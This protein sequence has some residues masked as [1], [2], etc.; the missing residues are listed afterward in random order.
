ME[1]TAGPLTLRQLFKNKISRSINTRKNKLKGLKLWGSTSFIIISFIS[2]FVFFLF[3]LFLFV[4]LPFIIL[5][6]SSSRHSVGG[7]EQESEKFFHGKKNRVCKKWH[8][9]ERSLSIAV[10]LTT[11]VNRNRHAPSCLPIFKPVCF[12]FLSQLISK[13]KP[14]EM[15]FSKSKCVSCYHQ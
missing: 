2:F 11:M 12:S 6:S 3:F 7:D 10:S 15:L 5:F 4:I 13:S 9:K 1:N 8:A 14:R